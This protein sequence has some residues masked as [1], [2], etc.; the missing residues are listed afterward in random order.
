MV[1]EAK[2]FCADSDSIVSVVDVVFGSAVVVVVA[3]VVVEVD[4][5]VVFRLLLVVASLELWSSHRGLD[6]LQ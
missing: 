4:V 3:D 5:G 2:Q 6:T 1:R